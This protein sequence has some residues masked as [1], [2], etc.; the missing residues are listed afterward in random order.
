MNNA[1]EWV[2]V[3]AALRRFETTDCKICVVTDSEYVVLGAGGGGGG[4]AR[5]W[6]QN[7]WVGSSGLLT[8]V[9]LWVELLDTL[10]YMGDRVQWVQVPSHV[11]LEGNE[12]ANDLAIAGMYQSPLW[13]GGTRETGPTPGCGSSDGA[14]SPVPF[15]VII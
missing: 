6:Q 4:A 5:K 12:I 13:G 8:N 11:G 3:I 2:D 9:R 14:G 15:G 10:S 7:G 1:A